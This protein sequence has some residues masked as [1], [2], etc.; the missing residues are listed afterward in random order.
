MQRRRR[1]EILIHAEATL[2]QRLATEITDKYGYTEII[3]PREGLTMMKVRESAKNSLFYLGEVLV[4]EARVRVAEAIG[5]GIVAG[6]K[7]H[8]ARNL[9]IIDAAYKA[10]VPETL[11]W[12]KHLLEAEQAIAK[13]RQVER[14]ALAQTKVRFETMDAGN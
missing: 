11:Q 4:T 13:Q 1:T 7:A 5:I 10:N 9:A 2:A 12:E 3:A 14:L 8:L 6:S